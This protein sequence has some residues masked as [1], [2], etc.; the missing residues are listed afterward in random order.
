[1][2]LAVDARRAAA[3][4]ADLSVADELL[5][6]HVSVAVQCATHQL[7]LGPE[8]TTKEVR[9]CQER[10]DP[11][12]PENVTPATD[13]EVADGEVRL[14]TQQLSSIESMLAKREKADPHS[15]LVQDYR[16]RAC[17][18]RRLVAEASERRTALGPREPVL[19]PAAAATLPGASQWSASHKRQESDVSTNCPSDSGLL[20]GHVPVVC[21]DQ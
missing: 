7:V 5:A 18:L 2:A 17:D 20:A 12:N 4:S 16:R 21:D 9:V 3:S 14:L 11:C 6:G 15:A 13:I 8:V 19:A 10:Y 1:M